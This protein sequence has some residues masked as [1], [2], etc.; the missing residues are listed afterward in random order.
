V[1]LALTGA[2]SLMWAE[3]V[4]LL[5][6]LPVC[7]RMSAAALRVLMPMTASCDNGGG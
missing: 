3:I 2:P 5:N 4:L 6:D 1:P 7:L